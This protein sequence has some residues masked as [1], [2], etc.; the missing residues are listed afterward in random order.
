LAAVASLSTSFPFGHAAPA[1]PKV[2]APVWPKTAPADRARS[3]NNL[4][5]IALAFHNH[6]AAFGCFPGAAVRGKDGRALLSW[7]V[8][9]LPFLEEDKLYRQFRLDEAWDGPNNKKLLAKMPAV[10]GLP[11]V[12]LATAHATFYR[13]FTGPDAPFKPALERPGPGPAGPRLVAITDGTSN[14]LLVV[15][16]GEAVPWTKPDELVYDAKKP[17]PKLGGLFP[18][19][20]HVAMMD[21]SVK[22]LSRKAP[23]IVLRAAITPH[24]GEVIDWEGVPLAKAPAEK[25]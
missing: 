1:P 21:G 6:E 10:Y 14:T 23:E 9:I 13:V 25:R 17:L 15:E 24:G 16:A 5:Q 18:E 2:P 12:K 19:G 11:R 8:A 4:K 3:A 22:F 7:R 20:I